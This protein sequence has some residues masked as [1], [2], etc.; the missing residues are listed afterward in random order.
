MWRLHWLLP[1]LC[2]AV[3]CAL[4]EWRRPLRLAAVAVGVLAGALTLLPQAPG[5]HGDVVLG[6]LLFTNPG[7]EDRTGFYDASR[8]LVIRFRAGGEARRRLW[9]AP[10]RHRLAVE[11]TGRFDVALDGNPV[12]WGEMV[13]AE[14]TLAGRLHQLR[15]VAPNGGE[16]RG[17]SIRPV[18]PHGAAVK[19]D[20]ARELQ[21]TRPASRLP[22]AAPPR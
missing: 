14:V 9:L 11:G 4:V 8:P 2:T 16:L 10:G 15:V 18:A 3:A 6:D 22:S 13:E 1:L 20:R 21:P 7:L 12:V 5:P 17:L 19:D